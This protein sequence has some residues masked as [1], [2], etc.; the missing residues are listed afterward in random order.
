MQHPKGTALDSEET[1]NYLIVCPKTKRKNPPSKL[2]SNKQANENISNRKKKHF[3]RSCLLFWLQAFGSFAHISLLSNPKP[4]SEPGANTTPNSD[5]ASLGPGFQQTPRCRTGRPRAFLATKQEKNPVKFKKYLH[6]CLLISWL[7]PR[8][9]IA[10]FPEQGCSPGNVGPS[11]ASNHWMLG[12][13]EGASADF[14]SELEH[15][16]CSM[17]T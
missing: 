3:M 6:G 16:H 5:A 7:Q 14:K 1:L 4:Q 2:K 12:L 9:E 11:A 10:T 15:Q 8:P 13:D 17:H